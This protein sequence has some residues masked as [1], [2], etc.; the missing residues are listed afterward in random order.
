MSAPTPPSGL[1]KRLVSNTL[2]AATGRLAAVV[3]WVLFTPPILR[4]LG[5]EGFAVWALFF[6]LTGYFAALDLGLVQGTLRHVAAARERGAHGEAGAF[7][8]LGL[9]GFLL[10]GL[11]WLVLALLLRHPLLE[12]LRIPPAQL[13]VA[14]FAMVAGAAVFALAGCAN[15]TLA[16][17]QGY[18]RFDLANLVSLLVTAQQAVGMVVV[19]RN[20]W[21]LW[22]L[23]L[24]GGVGWAVGLLSGVLALRR[25]VPAFRWTGPRASS[26]HLRDV[27]AFGGPM[28]LASLWAV[29]HANLD[30]FLL[31]VFVALSA[32]TPYELGSRVVGSI[33]A[34]P[35]MLLLA[36]LPAASALHAAG[37]RARLRELYARGDRYLLTA[38]ALMVAVLVG[39]A[40]RIFS[41]WLGPGHAEAVL[42]LRG[43]SLASGVALTTGMASVSARAVGRTD[44]EAWFGTIVVALH[45]ALSL[46]LLPRLGLAGAVIA[47]LVA[48]SIASLSFLLMVGRALHWRA[49]DVLVKPHGVP[50]LAVAVGVAAGLG[51][52]R[53][54][55][56]ATGITAWTLLA[57][58]AGIAGLATLGVLVSTGYFHWREARSLLVSLGSPSAEAARRS[59]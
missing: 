34:F 23:V 56:G 19:L 17:L 9:V 48:N 20:D 11:V 49:W 29:I 13:A 54:L 33:Q 36:M 27:L 44:L 14:G 43:L 24:N 15:V 35:Q 25:A 53:A 52:D 59:P 39:S 38:S 55:P 42:V 58:V 47:F 3:V 16:T 46:L 26:A 1:A 6:A 4:A 10:L 50:L 12:W 8:T 41:A 7:A 28:Q 45:L 51:L 40:D 22:G 5:V 2:H 31:P 37:D 18:D 32:V 57:L 21:G 30:K